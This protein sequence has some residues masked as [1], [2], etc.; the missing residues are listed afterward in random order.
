[1]GVVANLLGKVRPPSP[2][3]V[4]FQVFKTILNAGPT[5]MGTP[6]VP[7]VRPN[8]DI[9]DPSAPYLY[10]EEFKR[11]VRNY[12]FDGNDPVVGDD[13][14]RLPPIPDSIY[15][16]IEPSAPATERERALPFGYR[17]PLNEQEWGGLNAF[18]KINK[19]IEVVA[20]TGAA[21]E[22]KVNAAIETSYANFSAWLAATNGNFK[23]GEITDRFLGDITDQSVLI[24]PTDWSDGGGKQLLSPGIKTLHYLYA[25][26]FSM[27]SNAR[28]SDDSWY[29]GAVYNSVTVTPVAFDN[30]YVDDFSGLGGGIEISDSVEEIFRQFEDYRDNNY[31]A[32]AMENSNKGEILKNVGWETEPSLVPESLVEF[33]DEELLKI[34]FWQVKGLQEELDNTKNEKTKRAIEAE[35]KRIQATPLNR[36]KEIN[37]LSE[38]INWLAVSIHELMGDFPMKIRWKNSDL[39]QIGNDPSTEDKGDG[40]TNMLKTVEWEGKDAKVVKFHNLSSMLRELLVESQ[41][42]YGMNQ[43]ILQQGTSALAE[44]ALSRQMVIKNWHLLDVIRDW[45]GIATKQEKKEVQFMFDPTK[46]ANWDDFLNPKDLPV[47]VEEI[48]L[49]TEEVPFSSVLGYL[50]QAA[51]ITHA[52]HTVSLDDKDKWK[53][54]IKSK[55]GSYSNVSDKPKQDDDEED[56]GK[57]KDD[58]DDFLESVEQGF[59]GS[60]VLKPWGKPYENRPRIRDISTDQIK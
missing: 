56:K 27:S 45:I 51:A 20:F 46:P 50:T 13:D 28:V 26:F 16:K 54:Y 11:L 52:V 25:N 34:R 49:T 38:R 4:Y 6:A 7:L 60:A 29:H 19:D 48:D 22:E 3:Q 21:S 53:D 32:F 17:Q 47:Y 58:W 55:L 33:S 5:A 18:P 39:I 10:D 41:F 59:V 15:P 31:I 35:I 9:P 42:I 37:S 14:P 40:D 23:R 1:M 44:T 30:T 2:A 8:N 12:R 43:R 57:E 36:Y 24:L